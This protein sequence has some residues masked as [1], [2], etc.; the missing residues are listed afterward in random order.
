M[1]RVQGMVQGDITDYGQIWMYGTPWHGEA[2]LA[3]PEKAPLSGIYFLAH[4]QKNEMMQQGK[5]EALSR[6]FACS[7]LPF[8]SHE[9]LDFTLGFFEEVVKSV[10]CYELRFVPD[11]GVVGFIKEFKD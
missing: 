2:G 5:V 6:L 3:S 4:G 1:K 9:A 7:F 10:P 11:K 8:Y